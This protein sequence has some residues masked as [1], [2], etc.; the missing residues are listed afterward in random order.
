V[1]FD[2]LEK[3][4]S[5]LGLR[6]PRRIVD[7]WQSLA[8][9]EALVDGRPVA[10]KVVD[11]R[12]VDRAALEVRLAALTRLAADGEWV[13]GPV[14]VAGR[15]VNDLPVAAK[16]AIGNLGTAGNGHGTHA[17]GT[18]GSGT[19]A[20]AYDFADG[21][22]PDISRPEVAAGMGRALADLHRVMAR[23]PAYV[24]PGLAAFPPLSK[25]E[26][27]AADLRVPIFWL[28]EALPDDEAGPCQLLH[29]DFS[30]KNIRVSDR[31][32]RVFDFDDCGYGPVE[33]DLANTVYF[34]LFDATLRQDLDRYHR[35]RACFV[36][37]YRERSG[38]A[39]ADERMDALLHRRVLTLASW[40]ADP[41][42]APSG[43][44]TAS[45]E[46]LATLHDFVRRYLGTLEASGAIG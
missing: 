29:G 20:V 32:W 35:F 46:W 38:S 4:L 5:A 10:V 15:L 26:K 42:A 6:H 44:R 36:D 14:P 9:Y 37:G 3:S 7:G 39:P 27:V 22:V 33:L 12:L 31:G 34:V 8:V 30:A 45:A 17:S 13:C 11:P 19:I 16:S 2:A 24:L 41:G 23:L 43:I 28:D 40:L 21:E 25:L 1:D 18:H